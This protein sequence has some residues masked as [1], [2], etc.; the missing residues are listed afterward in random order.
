MFLRDGIIVRVV[1]RRDLERA[2]AELHAHV[3]V[4]DDRDLTIQHGHDGCLADEFLEA[5]IV[6]MHRHSR[7]AEDGFG[8]DGGDGDNSPSES[9]LDN[10][11]LK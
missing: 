10:I 1:P 6:R 11:Y 7:I 9:L 4:G 3:F 8:A 2:R 5:F